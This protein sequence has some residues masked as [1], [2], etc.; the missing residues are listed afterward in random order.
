M[1]WGSM[2]RLWASF[3]SS[4]VSLAFLSASCSRQQDQE[5]GTELQSIVGHD[6]RQDLLDDPSILG[7]VGQFHRFIYQNGYL[8]PVKGT[9]TAF[10]SG[11]QEVTTAGHCFHKLEDHKSFVFING[12]GEIHR[13]L[14]MTYRSDSAKGDLAKFYAPTVKEHFEQAAF[15]PSLPVTM[16]SY[17]SDL[18]K[19]TQNS[20]ET[21]SPEGS[22][23]YLFSQL[24]SVKGASGSPVLQ[25]GKVVAM[26]VAAVSR[27][28]KIGPSGN[29][30][31]LLSMLD[32]ADKSKVPGTKKNEII[33]GDVPGD[34]PTPTPT[35]T[36]N[37][38]KYVERMKYDFGSARYERY[39]DA[40]QVGTISIA[41]GPADC[42]EGV[43]P[44]TLYPISPDHPSGTKCSNAEGW[45]F[46][47]SSS[48]PSNLTP[49]DFPSAVRQT[50]AYCGD[51]AWPFE[52]PIIVV[53][54]A[55][56][57]VE[58][59]LLSDADFA[60]QCP[61]DEDD[62]SESPDGSPGSPFEEMSKVERQKYHDNYRRVPRQ[63]INDAISEA[64][65]RLGRPGTPD[66]LSPRELPYAY[67]RATNEH[68]KNQSESPAPSDKTYGDRLACGAA[69]GPIL[70]KIVET[71]LPRITP[72]LVPTI[73]NIKKE[74]L[75]NESADAPAKTP[76]QEK[77]DQLEKP[78]RDK[79][80]LD[81][82]V[83]SQDKTAR[84]YIKPGGKPQ[85]D[86]DY[87]KLEG[88]VVETIN[89][90][91]DLV[92]TKTLPSGDKAISRDTS[93]A[94]LPTIE[95][96]PAGKNESERIKIRYLP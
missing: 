33:P 32:R 15:D 51:T 91:G 94:D 37:P 42:G 54:E 5:W 75:H 23:G 35:P 88:P 14:G 58:K 40:Y 48:E 21:A 86:K 57:V 26:H 39:A 52:W 81:G 29:I 4:S 38:G 12:R 59:V 78:L 24:D 73:E 93:K 82:L 55:S 27:A 79:Q 1:K 8:L 70:R 31:V 76:A 46:S 80:I 17:S 41:S 16:A 10:A 43:A 64:L 7:K 36:Q 74:I 19:F 66:G 18:G 50:T 61:S 47:G 11:P 92:K 45:T 85:K 53:G 2:K 90:K 69:C 60:A 28:K 77:K 56:Q 25:G 30:H 62:G 13:L 44:R 3:V 34:L 65:K 87:D 84:Q 22:S 67:S 6:S 71:V 9:C 49:A 96:Q 68:L 89:S 83:P 20:V 95:I 72:I 63:V